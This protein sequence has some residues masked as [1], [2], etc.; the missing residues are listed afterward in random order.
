MGTWEDWHSIGKNT[1][2]NV[3]VRNKQTMWS[4]SMYPSLC[5][6]VWISQPSKEDWGR[7]NSDS[8][9]SVRPDNRKELK[10]Q[11]SESKCY[12]IRGGITSCQLHYSYTDKAC[13]VCETSKSF[14]Y[15]WSFVDKTKTGGEHYIHRLCCLCCSTHSIA[16]LH[17]Q[18]RSKR[19]KWQNMFEYVLS[20]TL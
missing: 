9:L 4:S 5:H 10:K 2:P 7:I 14:I 16:I 11:Q 3:Q 12:L 18:R 17:P 8:P 19:E 13:P 15:W 20:E 6:P 1:I